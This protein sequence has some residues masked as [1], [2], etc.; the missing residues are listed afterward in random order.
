MAGVAVA[1][2]LASVLAG[3][4]V[5]AAAELMVHV[6]HGKLDPAKTQIK[7]G[8]TIVFHN[9]QEMPGG[10]TVVADDGSFQSPPLAK[11][12]QWKKNFDQPGSFGVHLKE[13]PSV[14]GTIEVR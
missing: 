9:L 6:F 12:A 2:L 7:K 14:K 8:D 4:R 3:S 1:A 11:D 5:A 13:H 10:H